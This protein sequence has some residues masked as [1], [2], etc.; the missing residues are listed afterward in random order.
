[1]STLTRNSTVVFTSDSTEKTIIT[2]GTELG[3][4]GGIAY[5]KRHWTRQITVQFQTTAA[6]QTFMAGLTEANGGVVVVSDYTTGAETVTGGTY[7]LASDP[8][9]VEWIEDVYTGKH[10]YTYSLDLIRW[11]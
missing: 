7:Y 1:M 10:A 5:C 3:L 11:E 4:N 8:A 6:L 9:L 2:A